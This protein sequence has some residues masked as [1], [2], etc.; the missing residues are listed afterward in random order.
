MQDAHTVM[1][2]Q[3]GKNEQLLWSGQPRQG[4]VFRSNEIFL[5]PFSL[6]WGGF[7]IFWETA[8]LVMTWKV[9][10]D[11]AGVAALIFPIFGLPFVLIGLYLIFGRFIVDARRRV[12]THYGVTNQ[13]IIIITG[14]M[15]Q[16]VKSLNLR[17]L[18]DI[19]LSEKPDR[20]GTITFGPASPFAGCF[21]NT[22]WPGMP[23]TTPAFEM[24]QD[25]KKVYDLIRDVQ[26][27]T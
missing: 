27:K 13:R 20:T 17:T 3:I 12:K 22:S 6:L 2:S 23:V 21:G 9:P 14:L 16:H 1:R 5:I 11:G 19:S 8:A 18:S 26:S 25:A 24:I 7:A 10:K 15:T 4:I